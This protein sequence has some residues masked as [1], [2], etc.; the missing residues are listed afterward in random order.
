[1][2]GV[3]L[4][5]L[6]DRCLHQLDELI[7]GVDENKLVIVFRQHRALDGLGPAVYRN[8]GIENESM[9][10]YPCLRVCTHA[11]THPWH[12]GGGRDHGHATVTSNSNSNRGEEKR[13]MIKAE[14]KHKS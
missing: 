5:L 13:K 2:Q 12:R 8:V 9:N 4:H 6:L 3:V 14:E 10:T 7:G 1:M 11:V